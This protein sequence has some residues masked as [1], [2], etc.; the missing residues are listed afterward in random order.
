MEVM[1]WE[2][3]PENV[4][5]WNISDGKNILVEGISHVKVP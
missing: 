3:I 1:E 5:L 2:D 4:S